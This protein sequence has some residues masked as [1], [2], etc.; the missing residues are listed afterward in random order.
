LDE[1]YI[2]LITKVISRGKVEKIGHAAFALYSVL[3]TKAAQKGYPKAVGMTTREIMYKAKLGSSQRVKQTRDLLIKYG[4]LKKYEPYGA[5][6]E[7]L[8]YLEY[9]SRK[10]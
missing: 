4:L 8:Y 10:L 6:E 1:K 7:G 3:L 5:G 9:Q 2:E